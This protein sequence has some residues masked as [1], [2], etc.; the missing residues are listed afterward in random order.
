MP[1]SQHVFPACFHRPKQTRL[2]LVPSRNQC[3]A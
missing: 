3:K 2:V 1:F